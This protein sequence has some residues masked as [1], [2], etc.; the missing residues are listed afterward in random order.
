M[1]ERELRV[2]VAAIVK[3]RDETFESAY[4]YA[5][6]IIAAEKAAAEVHAETQASGTGPGAESPEPTSVPT[7]SAPPPALCPRCGKPLG[8][9]HA[10]IADGPANSGGMAGVQGNLAAPVLAALNATPTPKPT[11]TREEK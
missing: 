1:T 3:D 6:R 5:D 2:L 9:D 10:C 4:F 11:R 8:P 7:P